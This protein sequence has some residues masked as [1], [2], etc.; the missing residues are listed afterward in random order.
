MFSREGSAIVIVM[1]ATA[2]AVA[3]LMVMSGYESQ[4]DKD[5]KPTLVEDIVEN[6]TS[7]CEMPSTRAETDAYEHTLSNVL[8]RAKS[9][10]LDFYKDND[11]PVCLDERLWSVD[12]GMFGRD[13]KAMFYGGDK[14]VMSVAYKVKVSGYNGK[15]SSYADE[16]LEDFARKARKKPSMVHSGIR[17]GY[18]QYQSTGKSGYTDT[19]WDGA[20]GTNFMEKQP[21]LSK[22]PVK[23]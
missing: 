16:L 21:E 9:K 20:Y 15:V 18:T 17:F 1:G 10:Y 14:P 5:R 11:V 12:T 3:G 13:P 19:R 2:A 4:A 8:G 7:I 22:P 23:R 6:S